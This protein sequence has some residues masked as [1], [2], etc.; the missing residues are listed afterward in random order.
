MMFT[1]EKGGMETKVKST[2]SQTPL[3]PPAPFQCRRTENL[4]VK[5]KPKGPKM[6]ELLGPTDLQPLVPGQK[7]WLGQ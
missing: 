3:T 4:P 7:G 6:S 2:A 5:P 1:Q